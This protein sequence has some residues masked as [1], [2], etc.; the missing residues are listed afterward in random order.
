M[1]AGFYPE[2][3]C[4]CLGGLG[5]ERAERLCAKCPKLAV[6]P[7]GANHQWRRNPPGELSIDL[8]ADERLISFRAPRLSRAASTKVAS[9]LGAPAPQEP[10]SPRN[11]QPSCS[12]LLAIQPL[13]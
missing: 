4:F 7:E 11:E 9:R 5:P 13:L 12:N 10:G 1:V 8:V 3:K 6:R 2:L